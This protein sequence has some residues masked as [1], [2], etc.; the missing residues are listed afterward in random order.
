MD[1]K[2]TEEELVDKL[3]EKIWQI[4]KPVHHVFEE[5]ESLMNSSEDEGLELI[6]FK[7]QLS[8]VISDFYEKM[9]T[10]HDEIIAEYGVDKN[11]K[12]SA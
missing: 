8:E 7:L 2:F 12:F 3:D 11:G 4:Q 5:I 10:V 1:K 9:V 6:E